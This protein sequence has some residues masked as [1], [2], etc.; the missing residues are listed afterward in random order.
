M[1][2]VHIFLSFGSSQGSCGGFQGSV[3][4]AVGFVS[5]SLEDY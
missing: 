3:T 2:E 1:A 4:V 5:G